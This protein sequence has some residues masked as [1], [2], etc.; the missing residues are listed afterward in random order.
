M[1]KFAHLADVHVGNRQYGSYERQMDFAQAF[2]NAI[3]FCV[4]EKVDFI[5][6]SG[7]LFH[8]KSEIDPL[9][10][11]QVKKVLEIPKKAEIPVIAVEG[12][13]DS[14]YF[15]ENYTWLDY[16]AGSDL[17]INLKPSFDDGLVVEEWDGEGAYIDLDGVRI[18]GMKYYGSLTER[19]LDEYA[20]KIKR[21]GFTI[22]VSHIG[23][24]GY[25]K[26]MYG[27]IGSSKLHRLRGR[28]D[29]IALG[30]VHKAF[31]EDDFIFNPGS[32]EICDISEVDYDR[33]VFIVEFDGEVRYSLRNEFYKPRDFLIAKYRFKDR[34]FD[35]FSKFLRER[36][37][38]LNRPV[39]DL[40]IDVEREMRLK[41]NEEEVRKI[42]ERA[43]NPLL[44]RIHWNVGG[45]FTPINLDGE[46]RESIEK[47]VIKQLLENYSYGDIS[48]EVLD[49]KRIFNSSFNL[50]MVDRMVE[51]ILFES[52]KDDE[53]DYES[54]I[55]DDSKNEDS[56]EDSE[57]WDWR[58]AVSKGK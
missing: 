57:V 11:L 48:S 1:I 44:T 15:R 13:H 6:I 29:Y 3:K 17:L 14:T 8:K 22:F 52:G 40:T 19:I 58:S 37:R 36:A 31:V 33:G 35:D 7:D 45:Y 50:K 23:V 18:Y 55:E 56:E 30:H 5:I 46:A 53:K 27:C 54:K 28:V 38:N 4:S 32:L 20:K 24:E 49:L 34:S 16:L 9:T 43:C 21:S 41:I 12:N 47:S 39:V 51:D 10:L 42:V 26:N 25:V 2:L